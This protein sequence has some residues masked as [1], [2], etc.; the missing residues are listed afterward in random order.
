MALEL[1]W[2]F[3]DEDCGIFELEPN[4]FVMIS[5]EVGMFIKLICVHF[6]NNP[7]SLILQLTTYLVFIAVDN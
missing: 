6:Q 1:N 4:T 7:S 2:M 3:E 5:S